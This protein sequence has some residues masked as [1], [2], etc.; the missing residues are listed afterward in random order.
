MLDCHGLEVLSR[1]NSL[2]YSAN[3]VCLVRENSIRFLWRVVEGFNFGRLEASYPMV[4]MLYNLVTARR[5][6]IDALSYLAFFMVIFLDKQL[7]MIHF[8]YSLIIDVN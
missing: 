7:R 5:D 8:N 2:V 3:L 6:R 1:L 4:R